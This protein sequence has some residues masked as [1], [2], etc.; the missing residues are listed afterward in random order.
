MLADHTRLLLECY[1][2]IYCFSFLTIIVCPTYW[3]FFPYIFHYIIFLHMARRLPPQRLPVPV[4]PEAYKHYSPILFDPA[5]DKFSPIIE[6]H[7][8]PVT[9]N[10]FFVFSSLH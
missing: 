7:F 8:N 10:C 1:L 3:V 6:P 4:I 5:E 2:S 9:P